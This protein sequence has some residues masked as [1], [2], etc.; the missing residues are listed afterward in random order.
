MAKTRGG[1]VQKAR[2]ESIGG[3]RSEKTRFF[4]KS[5]CSGLLASSARSFGDERGCQARGRSG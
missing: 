4:F 5:G 1:T 3:E 2:G